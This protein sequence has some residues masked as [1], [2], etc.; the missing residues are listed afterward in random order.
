VCSDFSSPQPPFPFEGTLTA[1]NVGPTG[2]PDL[3]MVAEILRLKLST[4][5]RGNSGRAFGVISVIRDPWL[6]Y[7]IGEAYKILAYKPEWG[8]P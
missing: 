6:I 3:N 2:A 5:P 8:V 4:S 7:G 1:K